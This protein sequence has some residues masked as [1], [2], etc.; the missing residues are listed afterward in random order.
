MPPEDSQWCRWGDAR[1]QTVSY[2][3]SRDRKWAIANGG[4]AHRR[5]NKC[6]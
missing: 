6:Q 5:Y 1:R 4:V 3:W 2:A